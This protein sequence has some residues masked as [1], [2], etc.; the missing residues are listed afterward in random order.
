LLIAS[1]LALEAA[2]WR[3][4]DLRGTWSKLAGQAAREMMVVDGVAAVW[5][6]AARSPVLRFLFWFTAWMVPFDLE[7][8]LKYHFTKVGQQSRDFLTHWL[9]RARAHGKPTAAMEHLQA[10]LPPLGR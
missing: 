4:A 7:A 3:L 2:G 5:R 8:Y 9:A 1:I 6:L 10:A